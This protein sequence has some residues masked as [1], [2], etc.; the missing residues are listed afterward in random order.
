MTEQERRHIRHMISR[1]WSGW[2]LPGSTV[3]EQEAARE[4]AWLWDKRLREHPLPEA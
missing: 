1:I 4:W 2:H 3:E